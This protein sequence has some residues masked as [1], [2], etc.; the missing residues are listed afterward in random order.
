MGYLYGGPQ[1]REDQHLQHTKTPH[2]HMT[3]L[4]RMGGHDHN[5]CGAWP[6]GEEGKRGA[7]TRVSPM[8]PPRSMREKCSVSSVSKACSLG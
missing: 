6:V 3:M 8:R 5:L 4:D 2:T 7:R 1:L